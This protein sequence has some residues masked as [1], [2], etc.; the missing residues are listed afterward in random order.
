MKD[1]EFGKV[2]LNMLSE[3]NSSDSTEKEYFNYQDY[4]YKRIFL[5]KNSTNKTPYKVVSN[6]E[7][8]KIA[9][10]LIVASVE[11]KSNSIKP[12]FEVNI[13]GNCQ[14]MT[15]FFMANLDGLNKELAIES[16]EQDCFLDVLILFKTI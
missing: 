12:K 14:K 16:V 2:L 7:K 5:P 11:E 10:I 8:D 9:L 6:L 13:D 3:M 4:S 1:G 15:I